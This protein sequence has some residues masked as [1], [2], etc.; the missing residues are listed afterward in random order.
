MGFLVEPYNDPET[1]RTIGGENDRIN[2]PKEG[3]VRWTLQSN[4]EQTNDKNCGKR[5]YGPMDTAK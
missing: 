4:T 1:G 3:T 2:F 5:R